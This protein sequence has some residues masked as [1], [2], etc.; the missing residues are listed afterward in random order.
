MIA[1]AT[2]GRGG[3]ALARHFL[4][5]GDGAQQV[6]VVDV[7]GLAAA[8]TLDRGRP[9]E[10][11]REGFRELA[12]ISAHGL[13]D[14]W[15]HHVHVD[16]PPGDPDPRGTAGHFLRL[17]EQE[18]A[19]TNQPRIV[20]EH[21][22][23]GRVHWHVAYTLIG[24]DGRMVDGLSHHHRR[25]EKVS[26]ITE[27]E[28]GLA[29]TKGAHN[30]SVIAALRREG[31]DD[32][33][34][35]LERAGL[36][37]G[38][39]ARAMESPQERAQRERSGNPS[40]REIG[41]AC[42]AAWRESGTAAELRANLERR[43]L[44]L[45][46]G[47]KGLVV[48]DRAGTTHSLSRRLG[49]ASKRI[50]GA[51]I[52]AGEVRQRL[53]GERLPRSEIG[54]ERPQEART[55][56]EWAGDVQDAI[57]ETKALRGGLAS[58]RHALHTREISM[59]W[60][61]PRKGWLLSRGGDGPHGLLAVAGESLQGGDLR[62]MRRIDEE[63]RGLARACV[64]RIEEGA[65]PAAPIAEL[66]RAGMEIEWHGSRSGWQL[67]G[68]DGARYGRADTICGREPGSLDQVLERAC[69]RE[70]AQQRGDP[71]PS[72][73]PSAAGRLAR[74]AAAEGVGIVAEA[75]Q[76]LLAEGPPPDDHVADARAALSIADLSGNAKRI[77][78]ARY[79]LV[80]AEQAHREALRRWDERQRR[81]AE[82]RRR[83]RERER[84]GREE[85]GR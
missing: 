33:A 7:R 59:R 56:P 38:G 71:V 24:E 3:G 68:D 51:R 26:R 13:T 43:G 80:R 78:D 76:G 50:E 36:H 25:T 49:E 65:A 30:R 81:Q 53:S 19:L 72:R 44:E 32:V 45:R 77:G 84:R 12:E 1:G 4:Q 58:L 70:G 28:R 75:L 2:R 42:L 15:C 5:L 17:Y 46:Q 10:A 66:R 11:V 34:G 62:D 20:V 9:E 48:I 14:R 37:R 55:G 54:R 31:R 82:A 57:W 35:E 39:R 63:R 18:F 22:K 83:A 64:G 40:P 47:E 85:R 69:G 29:L 8:A 16:P 79:R 23:D 67:V 60:D 6:R 41:E 61:V 74:A 21:E 52:R 73:E 27:F